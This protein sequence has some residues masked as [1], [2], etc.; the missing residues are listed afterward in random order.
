[1]KYKPA[2]VVLMC[3]TL[4]AVSS[5]RN[6][7]LVL[8]KD[9]VKEVG[10]P[11]RTH[12]CGCDIII[13]RLQG[14][15]CLDGSAPGYYIGKGSGSGANKW[16]LHQGGGGWCNTSHTCLAR[17]KTPLGTSTLWNGTV[18]IGGI[19]SDNGT[20]NGE[21]HNWNVIYLMYCDGGSFSGYR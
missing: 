3:L 20:V 2:A 16:I 18:D 14:A 10:L 21:F 17:S 6:V 1:M 5:A 11:T 8:V 7:S 12:A 15:V 9:A 13:I 19:F 4:A